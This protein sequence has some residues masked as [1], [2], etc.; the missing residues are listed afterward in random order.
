MLLNKNMKI[1]YDYC[2]F[3]KDLT[4]LILYKEYTKG[5]SKK[6]RVTK[7]YAKNAHLIEQNINILNKNSKI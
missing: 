5:M 6:H 1:F 3:D 4:K 2:Y 7:E